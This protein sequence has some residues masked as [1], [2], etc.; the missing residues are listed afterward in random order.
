MQKAV[1]IF[2]ATTTGRNKEEEKP[3]RPLLLSLIGREETGE[4]GQTDIQ[5]KQRTPKNL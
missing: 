1:F 4:R 3:G 5:N 2:D